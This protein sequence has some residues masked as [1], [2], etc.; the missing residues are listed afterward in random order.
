MIP[1]VPDKQPHTML[2]ELARH[3]GW[4]DLIRE[5]IDGATGD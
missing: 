1:P 3:L 5:E 2:E 4:A